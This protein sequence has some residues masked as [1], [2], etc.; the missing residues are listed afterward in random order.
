MLYLS[1]KKS[2]KDLVEMGWPDRSKQKW[3]SNNIQKILLLP[4]WIKRIQP[5]MS[6]IESK[7]IKSK[8]DW[9]YGLHNR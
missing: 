6:N 8:K 1:I 2:L 5:Y 3:S 4:W 9:Y 7:I